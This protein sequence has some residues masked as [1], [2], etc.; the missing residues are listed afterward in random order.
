MGW[1]CLQAMLGAALAHHDHVCLVMCL[2]I[3]FW[4]VTWFPLLVD[5]L[6]SRWLPQVVL[7]LPKDD[8]HH[9]RAFLAEGGADQGA[10]GVA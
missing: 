8:E 3:W 1:V 10:H 9:W 5:V 2:H 6:C 7:I 4:H